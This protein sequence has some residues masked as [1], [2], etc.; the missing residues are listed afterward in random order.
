MSAI[1]IRKEFE[2]WLRQLDVTSIQENRAVSS[3]L[4]WSDGECESRPNEFDRATDHFT[5]WDV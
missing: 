5:L 2:I 4:F 3:S 1:L